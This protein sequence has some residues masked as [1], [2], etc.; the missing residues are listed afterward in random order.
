MELAIYTA[1]LPRGGLFAYWKQRSPRF[2]KGFVIRFWRL[3]FSLRWDHAKN[4]FQDVS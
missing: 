3:G 1:P 2:R 4:D